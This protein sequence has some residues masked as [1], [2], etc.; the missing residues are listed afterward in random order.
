MESSNAV[1]CWRQYESA[2]D[3]VDADR[4]PS[5]MRSAVL[6]VDPTFVEAVEHLHAGRRVFHSLGTEPIR[7]P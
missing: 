5:R 3:L 2:D 1:Y 4:T 7:A 6:E